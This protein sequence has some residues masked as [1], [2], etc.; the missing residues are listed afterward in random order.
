MRSCY[1]RM[2]LRRLRGHYQQLSEFKQ[3]HVIGLPEGA[4]SFLDIDKRLNRNIKIRLIVGSSGQGKLL[5]KEDRVPDCHIAL[6]R[7]KTGV[8]LCHIVLSLQ[9]NLELQFASQ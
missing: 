5:P 8:W 6:L 2:H 3:G 9:H 1:S 7:G 4:F